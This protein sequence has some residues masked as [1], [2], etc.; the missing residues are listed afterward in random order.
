[1]V[2]IKEEIVSST[3]IVG[4]LNTPLII[5]GR[6]TRDKIGKKTQDSKNIMNKLV[7]TDIYK[8]FHAETRKYTLFS[9]EHEAFLMYQ[10]AKQ[11]SVNLKG[12]KSYKISF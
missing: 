7:L 6:T 5:M 10:T 4:D 9:C 1:M 12:L 8:T 11:D 2:E 3:I